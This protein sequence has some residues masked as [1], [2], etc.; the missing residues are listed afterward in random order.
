VP[1]DCAL[2]GRTNER[3]GEIPKRQPT[4]ILCVLRASVFPSLLSKWK[5]RGTGNTEEMVVLVS[6]IGPR[7]I[8]FVI[9]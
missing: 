2:V 9:H 8:Q 4:T 1:R 3:R 5:H 6:A 7:L